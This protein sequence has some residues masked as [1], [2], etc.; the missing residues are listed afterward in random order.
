MIKNQVLI[1]IYLLIHSLICLFIHFSSRE[2]LEDVTLLLCR[3]LGFG[4]QAGW[5]RVRV[6]GRVGGVFGVFFWGWGCFLFSF[7]V[8]YYLFTVIVHSSRLQILHLLHLILLTN[9][10]LLSTKINQIL[11]SNLLQ[12]FYQIQQ[13]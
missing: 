5:R 3:I 12:F 7:L 10:D 6:R 4:W 9:Q 11:P 2:D 1:I 13:L 8:L